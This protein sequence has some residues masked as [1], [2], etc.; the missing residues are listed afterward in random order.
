MTVNKKSYFTGKGEA[1]EHVGGSQ[2]FIE[3]WMRITLMELPI[4]PTEER[5][6]AAFVESSMKKGKMDD[7]IFYAA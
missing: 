5:I 7:S 4:S 2:P 1:S 3:A 6:I